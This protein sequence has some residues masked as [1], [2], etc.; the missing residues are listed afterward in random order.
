MSRKLYVVLI[1]TVETYLPVFWEWVR[2]K[3]SNV[4][5]YFT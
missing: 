5:C 1:V 3:L 4:I 2:L